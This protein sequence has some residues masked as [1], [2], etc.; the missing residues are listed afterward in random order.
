MAPTE[1]P[2]SS[3]AMHVEGQK[4]HAKKSRYQDHLM[5]AEPLLDIP[6]DLATNWFC[7]PIPRGTRCLVVAAS[8]ITTS[9]S[10]D[11]K[12]LNRFPSRLPS[13]SK[14]TLSASQF[15]ILDCIFCEEESTYYCLDM[16]C[17][18]G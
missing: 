5:I 15:C 13:G 9:R 4:E 11:G 6:S 14:Y 1:Q 2:A 17:W 10:V 8:G 18:K 16:L 7:V 12:I 3:D